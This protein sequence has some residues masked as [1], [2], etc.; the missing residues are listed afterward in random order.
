MDEVYS[1][2]QCTVLLVRDDL[3][4]LMNLSQEM[5]CRFKGKL[6]SVDFTGSL[7]I[8]ELPGTKL[9]RERLDEPI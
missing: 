1:E 5:S 7:A 3:S 9:E 6:N 2:A 4:P 8:G